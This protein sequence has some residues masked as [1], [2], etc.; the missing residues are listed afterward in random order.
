MELHDR[1]ENIINVFI[2]RYDGL[3]LIFKEKES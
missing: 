1:I 2:S 3:N